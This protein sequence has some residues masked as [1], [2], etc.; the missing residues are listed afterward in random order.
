MTEMAQGDRDRTTKFS[1]A[2]LSSLLT[3]LR[4]EVEE[5][6]VGA[7]R[8]FDEAL[9]RIRKPLERLAAHG[10]DPRFALVALVSARWRSVRSP[11]ADIERGRRLLERLA[12]EAELLKFLEGAVAPHF[13]SAIEESLK[14]LKSF[15][16]Q[17]RG[18]FDS[19]G[20]RWQHADRRR[21]S[22]HVTRVAAVLDWHL[23]RGTTGRWHRRALV[24]QLLDGV[25]LLRYRRGGDPVE[26]VNRRLGRI[27]DDYYQKFAVPAARLMFHDIHRSLAITLGDV[28]LRRCGTACPEFDP[29]DDPLSRGKLFLEPAEF[30]IA[31][32]QGLGEHAVRE[33]RGAPPTFECRAAI[34]REPPELGP[35]SAKPN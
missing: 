11:G 18:I 33:A 24:A 17:D 34:D 13:T 32:G 21:E 9:T 20:T 12:A 31:A 7:G 28:S 4:Q 15:P 27:K 22:S 23:R 8:G 25:A 10:G 19:S 3:Y 16:W 6:R 5:V 26:Q 1:S 2:E 29:P 30:G 35:C 14:F